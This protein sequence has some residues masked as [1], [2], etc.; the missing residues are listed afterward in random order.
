MSLIAIWR[1]RGLAAASSTRQLGAFVS[2]SSASD[3]T[4]GGDTERP[5]PATRSV[6]QAQAPGGCGVH[7][8]LREG[9]QQSSKPYVTV[10]NTLSPLIQVSGLQGALM[11]QQVRVCQVTGVQ[12]GGHATVGGCS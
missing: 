7:W 1:L 5:G 3:K 9:L 6:Q 12:V 11:H 8:H 10:V 4:S 2:H